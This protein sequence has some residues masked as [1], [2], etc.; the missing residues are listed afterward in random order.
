[1]NRGGPVSPC[2]RSSVHGGLGKQPP[3]ADK[4]IQGKHSNISGSL[5]LIKQQFVTQGLKLFAFLSGDPQEGKK[6][7]RSRL[8][9]SCGNTLQKE[10]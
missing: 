2:T 1:M 7:K 4:S 9:S 3:T 5:V 10:N 8:P 6:K